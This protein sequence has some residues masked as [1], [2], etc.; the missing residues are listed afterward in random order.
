[1]DQD[2]RR[3]GGCLSQLSE[4]IE[5]A[6]PRRIL[7]L[8]GR[9]S[10]SGS[11]AK[12][13]LG[14][15]RRASIEYFGDVPPNPEI[16][17]VRRCLGLFRASVPDAVVAIGGGSIID[18]AKAVIAFASGA[19]E[20]DI[21]ANRFDP[22]A[23][24]PRLW[25]APTT[26]GSGSE[27]T[28]FAVLYKG[29]I[30]YSIAHPGLKPDAVFLDPELTLSC[31]ERLTLA[32]GAD[33]VCQAVESYWSKGGTEPSRAFALRALPLL[34]GNIFKA[35]DH[36]ESIEA[37]TA[38]LEGAHLAGKAIDISKT[39]AGHAL[40]YGLTSRYGMQHGLAVLAVMGPLVDM[41][42]T[43]HGAFTSS[44]PLDEAFADY[45]KDFV[46]GFSAFRH[47]TLNRLKDE[48]R[49]PARGEGGM[50]AQALAAT[51]NAER[52][53]N[54]PSAL[55]SGDIVGLYSEILGD[56]GATIPAKGESV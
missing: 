50:A 27:A 52:L 38:M 16:D 51:V 5:R 33:A 17:T 56:L 42:A 2:V 29:G 30:K 39:T 41:M 26:A 12:E 54:H 8:H 44:A 3:G 49:F 18:T 32:S 21:L 11:G 9:A 6:R 22:G 23:A 53:G 1:M 14:S 35:A 24:R 31:P 37:R 55:S 25:A 43:K 20:S 46:S 47:E 28:H 36:P 7:V 19:A 48:E 10:F 4:V 13:I 15:A 34:L 40:S 45:G